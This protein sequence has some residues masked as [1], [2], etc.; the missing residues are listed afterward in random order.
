MAM[1]P[2]DQEIGD[3]YREAGASGPSGELD[4]NIL[5]AAR[6]AVQNNTVT[7]SW[8]SRW[9]LPLQVVTTI[10]LIIM[11]TVMVEHREPVPPFIPPLAMNN[12]GPAA[13]TRLA[14]SAKPNP[15]PA[16]AESRARMVDQAP[17]R[18]RSEAKMASPTPEPTPAAPAQYPARSESVLPAAPAGNSIASE[19]AAAGPMA[20][21]EAG[22]PPSAKAAARAA[23]DQAMS[24]K[25]WLDSI[26]LLINQNRLEEGRKRLE[27]FVLAYPGEVV[28]ETIRSK[29]K[30]APDADRPRLP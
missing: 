24:P 6:T 8:W 26:Q 20:K 16:I 5:I 3:L 12:N 4:Q 22:A 2:T 10:C 18:A 13:E 11:V 25:D 1:K 17:A 30:A 27:A 23:A 28:P 9:R 7:V 19:S 15:A 29:L 21:P 14:E